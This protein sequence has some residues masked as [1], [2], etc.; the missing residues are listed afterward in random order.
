MVKWVGWPDKVQGVTGSS[1]RALIVEI[2]WR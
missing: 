1:A 2:R